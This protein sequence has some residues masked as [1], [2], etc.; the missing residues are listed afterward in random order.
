[1]KTDGVFMN[2]EYYECLGT[3]PQFWHFPQIPFALLCI[4]NR[5]DV[6]LLEP[7]STASLTS[8][9][10]LATFF[11]PPDL[12]QATPNPSAFPLNRDS[13]PLFAPTTLNTAFETP[14]SQHLVLLSYSHRFQFQGIM[15]QFSL[16]WVPHEVSKLA[17]LAQALI[18]LGSPS[19]QSS[20]LS[21]LSNRSNSLEHPEYSP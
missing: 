3:E 16:S 14:L 11:L 13:S 6:V 2:T 20:R 15:N 21:N 10:I 9:I 18:T 17:A 12:L 4:E 8:L 7:N 5:S 1:M 19:D